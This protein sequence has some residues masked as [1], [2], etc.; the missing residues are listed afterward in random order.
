MR[1]AEHS[2]SNT[3]FNKKIKPKIHRKSK[4]NLKLLHFDFLQILG[5]ILLLLNLVFEREW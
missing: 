2:I 3:K 1:V 4:P 5:L